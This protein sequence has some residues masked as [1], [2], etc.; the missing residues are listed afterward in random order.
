LHELNVDALTA[1][2]DIRRE[3]IHILGISG[4]TENAVYYYG[5]ILLIY[6]NFDTNELRL[7]VDVD[8]TWSEPHAAALEK[9][10]AVDRLRITAAPADEVHE[11]VTDSA[12]R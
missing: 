4:V 6:K 8:G 10:G 3:P 11:S 12:D 1:A 5:A 7:G 2:L 9:I